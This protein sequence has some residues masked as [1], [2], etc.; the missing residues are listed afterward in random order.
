[1]N[2]RTRAMKMVGCSIIL[3]GAALLF[4]PLGIAQRVAEVKALA[5]NRDVYV[6]RVSLR[7]AKAR[8][9]RKFSKPD[10]ARLLEPF[11]KMVKAEYVGDITDFQFRY[12]I[13]RTAYVI[14]GQQTAGAVEAYAYRDGEYDF[15]EW[16]N[17]PSALTGPF[18]ALPRKDVDHLSDEHQKHFERLFG[19]E[20]MLE[21]MQLEF[22]GSRYIIVGAMRW[23]PPSTHLHAVI[24]IKL[25]D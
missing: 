17:I 13:G 4:T 24:V 21:D 25:A 6:G 1:M 3:A 19:K 15:T 18:V 8:A 20:A 12:H 10:A 23:R 11:A 5:V 14:R 22:T 2:S 16:V 9:F 7:K